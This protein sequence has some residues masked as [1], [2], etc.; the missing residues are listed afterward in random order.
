MRLILNLLFSGVLI[1]LCAG[2]AASQATLTW[3]PSPST[4]YVGLTTNIASCPVTPKVDFIVKESGYNCLGTNGSAA[5]FQYVFYLYRNGVQIAGFS[6]QMTSTCGMAYIFPAVNALPGTYTAK[7]VFR[8]IGASGVLISYP[9]VTTLPINAIQTPAKPAFRINSGSNIGPL[10]TT[11]NF[12]TVN[13][14][15][16]Q[17]ITI[18]ATQTT[19]ETK[20]SV[21]VMESELNWN[22]TYQYEWWKWFPGNAPNNINLQQLSTTYSNP[23]DYTG[24]PTRAGTPLFGGDLSPGVPRYYRV[25]L[26]TAEPSWACARSLLRINY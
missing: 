9:P 25:E 16:S 26:C 7:V 2:I 5:P 22:R 24:D 13:V 11:T 18:D 3:A 19:C 15:I 12:P 17:P 10:A 4:G 23:P 6:S 14:H 20:Y 1:F 21:S 8:K